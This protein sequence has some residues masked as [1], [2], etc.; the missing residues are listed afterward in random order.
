MSKFLEI[1]EE[2]D[3]NSQGDP[4][5]E[6]IDYLKSMGCKVSLVK[7][8]DMIYIDTGSKT[9]PVTV[10]SAQEDDESSSMIDDIANDK[11]DK[12]Q[13]PAA[14]VVKQRQ[15]LAPKIIKNAQQRIGNVTKELN[16]PV[17]TLKG[18]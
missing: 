12:F 15:L 8:T 14:Q 7:G 9:I 1:C 4:K 2:F 13:T 16:R 17:N 5:W 18:L 6:L 3:P 10:S 11:Q